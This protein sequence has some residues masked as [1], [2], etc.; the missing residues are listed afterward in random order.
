MIM[1]DPKAAQELVSPPRT[2]GDAI[3][4]SISGDIDL[5][6]SPELRTAIFQAMSGRP[7][8]KFVLNLQR[9]SYMDSSAVAVLVELLQKMRP[10]GGRVFLVETQPRVRG[11]LEIARLNSIFIL[12]ATEEEALAK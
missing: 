8:K 6:N 2:S 1:P 5:H 4:L 3:L 10:L 7:P 12:S 9:V 11:L